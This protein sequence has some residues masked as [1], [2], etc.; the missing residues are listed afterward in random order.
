MNTLPGRRTLVSSGV[1]KDTPSNRDW[2][3]YCEMTI[4]TERMVTPNAG[5]FHH[6]RH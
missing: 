6:W 1:L 3:A 2:A 4:L 5:D